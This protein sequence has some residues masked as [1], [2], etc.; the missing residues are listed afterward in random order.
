MSKYTFKKSERLRNS[1]QVEKLFV[2]GQSFI[3][4][5][6]QVFW[7]KN[8]LGS[9]LQMAISIPKKKLTRAVDR[10]RMKRLVRESFR[11]RKVEWTE[12][13]HQESNHFQILLVFLDKQV[14]TFNELDDKIS[15]ILKRLYE[16]S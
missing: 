1:K 6:F 5:P 9:C 8:D 14:L 4:F 7:D 16:G 3:V 13:N 2:S 11:L 10:N 12:A 15:V